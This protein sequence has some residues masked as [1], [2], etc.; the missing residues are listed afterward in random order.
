MSDQTAAGLAAPA[1]VPTDI[2]IS[3]ED[4]LVLRDL[5]RDSLV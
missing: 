1:T 2:Y 3:P 5:A 4:R